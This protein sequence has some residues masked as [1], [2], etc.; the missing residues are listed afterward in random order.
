MRPHELEGRA[1]VGEIER[2]AQQAIVVGEEVRPG[3]RPHVRERHAVHVVLPQQ[4]VGAGGSLEAA[5]EH[6]HVH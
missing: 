5:S 6:Q 4:V 3:V 1:F 2:D